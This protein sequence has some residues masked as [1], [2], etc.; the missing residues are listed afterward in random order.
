MEEYVYPYAAI[1][2]PLITAALIISMVL[3]VKYPSSRQYVLPC[4]LLLAIFEF[5]TFHQVWVEGVFIGFITLTCFGVMAVLNYSEELRSRIATGVLFIV[6]GC[7]ELC[8]PLHFLSKAQGVEF[9]LYWRNITWLI[10]L[11]SLAFAAL[12]GGILILI[13]ALKKMHSSKA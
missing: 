7:L 10:I 1:F 3:F 12:V 13:P 11:F 6:L 4:M 9:F 2:A 8:M 5:Y